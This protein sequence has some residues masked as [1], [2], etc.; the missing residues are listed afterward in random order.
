MKAPSI[1]S[2]LR[3]FLPTRLEHMWISYPNHKLRIRFELANLLFLENEV[4]QHVRPS[5]IH[6]CHQWPLN[7]PNGNQNFRSKEIQIT[8][9]IIRIVKKICNKQTLKYKKNRLLGK[10]WCWTSISSACFMNCPS[11]TKMA[12][13]TLWKWRETVSPDWW[14]K[15]WNT[16]IL[17]VMSNN[18]KKFGNLLFN[19]WMICILNNFSCP[20]PFT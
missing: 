19:C 10:I 7:N 8:K 20:N 12:F 6:E 4:H 3:S 15:K 13:N 11:N 17:D 16:L 1:S 14:K 5:H 18:M 2:N 9:D